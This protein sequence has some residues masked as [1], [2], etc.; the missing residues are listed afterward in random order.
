[1]AFAWLRVLAH[2]GDIYIVAPIFVGVC[3]VL[4]VR[5]RKQEVI[6]W[7]VIF[8][9]AAATIWILKSQVGPFTVDLGWRTVRAPNLPSGHVGMSVIL[10]GQAAILLWQEG[11]TGHKLAGVGV[12]LL[13][14]VIGTAVYLVG[15]HSLLDIAA[16]IAISGTLLVMLNLWRRGLKPARALGAA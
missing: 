5:D 9:L 14:L 7:G 6:S 15:W 16:A 13:P 4:W 1:M 3:A 11:S 10:Y 8:C 2:M 12:A